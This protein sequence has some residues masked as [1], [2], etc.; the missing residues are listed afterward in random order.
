MDHL[1]MGMTMGGPN[2]VHDRLSDPVEN[3]QLE[4]ES[5]KVNE[6]FWKWI[7]RA[8][9]NIGCHTVADSYD[10]LL[11]EAVDCGIWPQKNEFFK[12]MSESTN[13]WL[14]LAE[15]FMHNAS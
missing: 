5:L 9:I 7:D 12:T 2:V 13:V 11:F 14:R 10:S 6:T 1:G 15:T 8:E 4:R 3:E